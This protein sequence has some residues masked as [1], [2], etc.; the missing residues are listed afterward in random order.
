MKSIVW[1]ERKDWIE[2]KR[3]LV[4]KQKDLRNQE[5][6][7]E[8]ERNTR[9]KERKNGLDKEHIQER[10]DLR[11]AQIGCLLSETET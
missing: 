9:F 5:R 11:K 1:K 2:R 7:R 8:R 3:G 4:S 6:Y 10:R